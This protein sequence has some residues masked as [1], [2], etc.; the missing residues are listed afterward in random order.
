M[1]KK[2]RIKKIISRRTEIDAKTAKEKET[3]NNHLRK[4]LSQIKSIS[5]RID[6]L[7]EIA[8]ALSLN[9]FELGRKNEFRASGMNHNLGFYVEPP[10]NDYKIPLGIGIEGGG[11]DGLDFV[12][13]YGGELAKDIPNYEDKVN[14]CER[15]LKYFD[16]FEMNFYAYVDSL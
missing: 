13:G 2:E 6:D 14:K 7:L 9:N 3:K 10:K 8:E 11:Y 4:L 5:S 1:N 16:E 12:V 15:F